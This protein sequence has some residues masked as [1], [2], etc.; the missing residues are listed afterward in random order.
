MKYRFATLP[1]IS[2][3][4]GMNLRLTEDENHR[5]RYK[6]DQW[7]KDRM[8]QFI[9]GDYKAVL[10]EKEGKVVA[11]ALYR[12]HPD[13]AD[14]IY[15][16]QIFI[17]RDS[18]RQGIGREVMNILMTEIWPKEKRLTVEVLSHNEIARKF[19]QAIG[20]KEYCLELEI[21]PEEKNL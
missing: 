11:Y 8:K 2:I 3:L 17:E 10:F 7:F 18:R 5:N 15:L 14:T 6:S 12:N 21:K 9:E 19:F 4:A 20:Y 16:R 1:D 13:H